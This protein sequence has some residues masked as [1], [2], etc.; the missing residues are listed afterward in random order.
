M[1]GQGDLRGRRSARPVEELHRPEQAVLQGQPRRPAG[2]Q[3]VTPS[4]DMGGLVTGPPTPPDARRVPA[5]PGRS[6]R[7]FVLPTAQGSP[8]LIE[9]R[10]AVAQAW[11]GRHRA[12]SPFGT[13]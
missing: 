10:F 7:P 5:K 8:P 13:G 6:S 3:V 11:K 2:H 4:T 1:P 9:G 12:R